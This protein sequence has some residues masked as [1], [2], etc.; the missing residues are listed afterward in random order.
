M[1]EKPQ[2]ASIHI[3]FVSVITLIVIMVVV[4]GI[5]RLTGSGLSIT[6]WKPIMGAIPPL[7]ETDWNVAFEKYKQIPQFQVINSTMSLH[8]F[9][10]IFFWEWFHRLIARLIGVI[11]LVP[12]IYFIFKKQISSSIAKKVAFGFLLG[13]AQ[14]FLGWFMV[15]SGLSQ[16]VYVSHIRLAA[17]LLLALFILGFWLDLYFQWRAETS[18]EASSRVPRTLVAVGVLLFIQLVYGAFVAGLKAGYV[19]NTFPKMNEEWLPADAVSMVPAWINIFQNQ[20]MVQFIHRW[21]A[22]VLV[23]AAIYAWKKEPKEGRLFVALIGV[24]FLLGV[25]TLVLNMPI[26]LASLHQLNACFLVLSYTAWLRRRK[27]ALF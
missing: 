8:E 4:G 6:E 17:H 20:G 14:G 11:V 9:K 5:T 21:L 2:R 25:L 3:W 23:I 26:A 18:R 22:V 10:F 7:N 19:Y 13:G 12:G 15:S 24:Q 1:Q 16:L 27:Y